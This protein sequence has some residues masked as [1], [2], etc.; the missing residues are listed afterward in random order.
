VAVLLAE[1]A[2]EFAVRIAAEAGKPLRDARGEV[3]RCLDTLRFSAVEARTLSGE[4][5]PMEGSQSGAGRL[6]FSKRVPLGVVAAITPFNL[7]LS[8]V[9]HKVG[10]AIAAGCP[11]VLKP[12]EQA[13]L[14][15]IALVALLV[16]AGLPADW[17][18]VVT[19]DGPGAGVP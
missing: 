17:I 10:P 12:A 16:E 8:L 7:P 4:L 2:E 6:G 19:G 1:R 11:V 9:A 13:P 14:S 5:L 18:S 15:A 3:A